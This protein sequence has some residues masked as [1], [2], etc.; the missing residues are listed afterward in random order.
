MRPCTA[1]G[2]RGFAAAGGRTRQSLFS[3]AVEKPEEERKPER[4]FGYRKADSRAG[5]SA[6]APLAGRREA[7]PGM[8]NAARWNKRKPAA[9]SGNRKMERF[10]RR[11]RPVTDVIG[12]LAGIQLFYVGFG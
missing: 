8:A 9:S 12:N 1:G 6:A 7:G 11:E 10:C 2:R 3:A 5:I 4:F